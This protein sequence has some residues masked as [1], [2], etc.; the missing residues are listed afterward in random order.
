MQIHESKFNT[1]YIP[2]KINMY[3]VDIYIY[4]YI[5]LDR[6]ERFMMI[7]NC[8]KKNHGITNHTTIIY[9]SEN[10]KQI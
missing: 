9:V 10:N 7:T 1:L 3:F 8:W 6:I 2:L 4:I 5:A